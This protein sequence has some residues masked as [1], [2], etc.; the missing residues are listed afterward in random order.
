MYNMQNIIYVPISIY[1]KTQYFNKLQIQKERCRTVPL[2]MILLYFIVITRVA[3][4]P[5]D[6]KFER[7]WRES[8]NELLY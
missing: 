5:L 8:M 2:A 6:V 1:F 7:I 3:P 4:F